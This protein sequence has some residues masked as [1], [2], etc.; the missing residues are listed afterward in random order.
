MSRHAFRWDSLVL[1]LLFAAAVGGWA[2]LDQDAL[3][4][5]QLSVT[6]SVILILLGL[7]G[8]AATLVTPRR[9]APPSTSSTDTSST[10]TQTR[11]DVPR[12]NPDEEAD[13]QS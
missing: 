12:G 2:V 1:G 8:V 13:P 9:P 5:R 4:A 3:T 7:L 11:T 6:A 10:D